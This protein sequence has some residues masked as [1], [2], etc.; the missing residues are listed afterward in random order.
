MDGDSDSDGTRYIVDKRILP[1]VLSKTIEAKELLEK[2]KA[3]TVHEAVEMVGMSRSAYYKYRDYIFPFYE[4]DEGKIITIHLLLS[5]RKGILSK[6]LNELARLGA[7][8]LTINQSIPIH[9]VANVTIAIEVKKLIVG[10]Q[11]LLSKLEWIEGVNEVS[12]LAR[13]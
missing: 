10:V 5:H 8:I 6:V 2:G 13:E 12:L 3:N 4:I 11:E 7:N 1:V 9:G